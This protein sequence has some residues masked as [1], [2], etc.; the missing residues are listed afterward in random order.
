M[1]NLADYMEHNK[2]KLS[3]D[4]KQ[5]FYLHCV[6]HCVTHILENAC[7]LIVFAEITKYNE[8]KLPLDTRQVLF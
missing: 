6:M 1:T 4:T 3:S 7:T 5:L 2:R 8:K